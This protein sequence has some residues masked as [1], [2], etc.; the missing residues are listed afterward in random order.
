MFLGDFHPFYRNSWALVI[1]IN[2]YEHASPL[3]YAKNDAESV[4]ALLI[5]K[6]GFLPEHVIVLTDKAASKEAIL[7]EYLKF[8]RTANSPDDRVL[9]FFAGHGL[10]MSGYQGSVGYLVPADGSSEN[11][12]SLIRWDDLTRNTD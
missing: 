10:T 1:G 5:S 7:R 2:E 12:A 4:A 11:V 6:V 8:I 3:T 9:F